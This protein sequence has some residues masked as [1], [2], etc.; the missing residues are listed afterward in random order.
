MDAE[1]GLSVCGHWDGPVICN[2]IGRGASAYVLPHGEKLQLYH[3]A[4]PCSGHYPLNTVYPVP[5][6]I[7]SSSSATV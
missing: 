5:F 2:E 4:P 3:T 1:C 6:L 7:G